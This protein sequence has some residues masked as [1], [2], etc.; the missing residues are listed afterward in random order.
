MKKIT[1][2]MVLVFLLCLLI[3]CFKQDI[4]ADSSYIKVNDEQ[5]IKEITKVVNDAN[6]YI[7]RVYSQSNYYPLSINVAGQNHQANYGLYKK[8]N[9]IAYWSGVSL[10]ALNSNPQDKIIAKSGD[11]FFKKGDI[12]YRYIGYD[13]NGDKFFNPY[14]PLDD[15]AENPQYSLINWQGSQNPI[16]LNIIS[17]NPELKKHIMANFTKS[18]FSKSSLFVE[19]FFMYRKKSPY[20]AK[21][22]ERYQ[23]NYQSH[24]KR[25][26]S[27]PNS[28]ANKIKL[29]SLP[30]NRVKGFAVYKNSINY[31]NTV[32]LEYQDDLDAKLEIRHLAVED[33]NTGKLKL[34]DTFHVINSV[35]SFVLINQG[36]NKSFKA[37]DY[38]NYVCLGYMIYKNE[39][40][41]VKAVGTKGNRKSISNYINSTEANYKHEYKIGNDKPIIVFYYKKTGHLPLDKASGNIVVSAKTYDVSRAIPSDKHVKITVNTD[42]KVLANYHINLENE[43][44]YIPV[45]TRVKYKEEDED[46][47]MKTIIEDDEVDDIETTYSYYKLTDYSIYNLKGAWV[48]NQ[49]LKYPDNIYIS[50]KNMGKSKA[51]NYTQHLENINIPSR[52]NGYRIKKEYDDEEETFNIIIKI[53]DEDE[54]ISDA[55]LDDIVSEL[56][57][58]LNLRVKN[59]YLLINGKTVLDDTIFDGK[60]PP[61][62]KDYT[63]TAFSF[64]KEKHHIKAKTLNGNAKTT[65]TLIYEKAATLNANAPLQKEYDMLGNDVF[66][67]TPATN[68]TVFRK[69]SKFDQRIDDKKHGMAVPLDHVMKLDIFTD[70]QHINEKGY[71]FKDYQEHLKLKTLTFDFDA[72]VSLNK[73]DLEHSLPLSALYLKKGD[74]LKLKPSVKTVY[75]KAAPWAK[76]GKHIITTGAIAKNAPKKFKTEK[77]ANLDF[78]HYAAFE[79]KE[80]ILT[81]RIFDFCVENVLDKGYLS[82]DKT[83]FYSTGTKNKE[84]LK[85]KRFSSLNEEDINNLIMPI[86]SGKSHIGLNINRNIKMGYPFVFSIKT[87]GT[88][89]AEEDLISLKPRFY[90]I[91]AQGNIDPN[92]VLYYRNNAKLVKVGSDQ[93]SIK[94][95]IVYKDLANADDYLD[96]SN[97]RELLKKNSETENM[98]D[99]SK[100]AYK[101]SKPVF[102][103]KPSL[104][105]L[106]YPFRTFI[107]SFNNIPSS[108]KADKVLMS[109]QKWKGVYA[110]PASTLAFK[111]DEAGKP[112]LNNALKTGSIGIYFDIIVSRNNNQDGADIAFVTNTSNEYINEGYVNMQDGTEYITGTCVLYSIEQS[113][114]EDLTTE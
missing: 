35:N 63:K 87:M 112:D 15:L 36:E 48:Q 13:A 9:I 114:D 94:Q 40:E 90:Y 101:T 14:F 80:V 99:Y 7:A 30:T 12:I 111:V 53:D 73:K 93:D 109:V 22:L 19:H 47:N 95:S 84:G 97:T 74:I 104:S 27:D 91:D 102:C 72:Y 98:L 70:Y 103:Y 18:L 106:S 11:V 25:L 64:A 43:R 52:I 77:N 113:A 41:F 110:L 37:K 34:S 69:D 21:L 67:H 82:T 75:Y 79:K 2:L 100:Y 26:F 56:E 49:K 66:I 85:R 88:F 33:N 60:N 20:P 3:F 96:I 1:R 31:Y 44:I 4:W 6:N 83:M 89:Y 23:Q 51:R 55:D 17:N 45:Y 5:D 68:R 58:R 24:L 32:F 108:V 71:G 76:E 92:I 54:Y 81:P 39:N 42:A 62:P 29:V 16:W 61:E 50:A 38:P 78:N 105:I 65:G 10:D 57:N 46:G 59:D 28:V 107:A 8:F 86:K